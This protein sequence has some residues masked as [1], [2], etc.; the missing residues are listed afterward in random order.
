MI[1]LV[2]VPVLFVD[3]Q[4]TLLRRYSAYISQP[5]TSRFKHILTRI[6]PT[7]NVN[8]VQTPPNPSYTF[9]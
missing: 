9:R 7:S 1:Q 8:I 2:L 4:L 6:T 5:D 3:Y